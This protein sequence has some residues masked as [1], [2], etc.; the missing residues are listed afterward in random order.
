MKIKNLLSV[1]LILSIVFSTLVSFSVSAE[2]LVKLPGTPTGEFI[3]YYEDNNEPDY[4]DPEVFD[5]YILEVYEYEDFKYVY[6]DFD[7]W[8]VEKGIA[9]IAYTGKQENLVIPECFTENGKRHKVVEV[10]I[11]ETNEYVKSVSIYCEI[12]NTMTKFVNLEEVYL[13]DNVDEIHNEAF[14]GLKNLKIIRGGEH[15]TYTLRRIY[16]EAFCGCESLEI[17]KLRIDVGLSVGSAAFLGCKSL[18]IFNIKNSRLKNIYISED[19]F[20]SCTSLKKFDVLSDVNVEGRAFQGCSSLEFVRFGADGTD[21]GEGICYSAFK[22]CK[23]LKKVEINQKIKRIKTSAFENCTS[24]KTV[25]LNKGYLES[26][27]KNA[28]KNCK[29]LTTVKI[30]N[31]SKTPNIH[32]KAFTSAKKGIKFYVM[33]E[34]VA[35]KLKSNLK[36]SNAKSPK[37][38]VKKYYAY[39]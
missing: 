2:E 4:E 10:S 9:I 12:I 21:M 30:G 19:A 1:L 20:R 37:I 27:N 7:R 5:E 6:F 33:K 39:Y 28:F 36:K 16:F 8:Y 11:R 24:L 22:D 34:K 25:K 3:T 26:I 13:M 31:E 23:K 15:S 17:V 35:K 32:K 18:K 29:K 38:Y 14:Y